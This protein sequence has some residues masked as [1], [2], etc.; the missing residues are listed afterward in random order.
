M[1]LRKGDPVEVC[2]EEEGFKGAWFPAAIVRKAGAGFL[3]EFRDLVTDDEKSKLR[4]KVDADQIRPQP[5]NLNKQHYMLHEKVDAYDQ[6][7]WWVGVI[8]NVGAHNS[9]IVY[10]S[11]TD[12]RLEYNVSQLRLHLDWVDDKW[13]HPSENEVTKQL[14]PVPLPTCHENTENISK[15]ERRS[16]RANK[17]KSNTNVGGT[18]AEGSQLTERSGKRKRAT[19]VHLDDDSPRKKKTDIAGRD[20]ENVETSKEKQIIHVSDSPAYFSKETEGTLSEAQHEE[21]KPI[22]HAIGGKREAHG[23]SDS[24]STADKNI[25]VAIPYLEET[26]KTTGYPG[27]NCETKAK[28]NLKG[29]ELHAYHSVL[30]AF[31]LQGAHTWK[32]EEVLTDLREVLHISHEEHAKELRHI[33]SAKY[34]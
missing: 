1:S 2:S 11:E 23:A 7:G 12:E 3:V 19:N 20:V 13:L 27:N 28:E 16:S 29:I 15:K 8:D 4:E 18:S 30:K 32:I 14:L 9:Y 10:F 33:T 26:K 17:W 25:V 34:K 24:H 21:I 5:P 22:L 31:Y 6:D